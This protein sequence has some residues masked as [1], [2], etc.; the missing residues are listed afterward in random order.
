MPNIETKEKNGQVITFM[1]DGGYFYKKGIEAYQNQSVEKAIQFFERA[2]RIE[3]EEPVFACQL[4]I[5]LSEEGKYEESNAWLHKIKDE[6]DDSMSECYFFL[7]NNQAHLGEFDRASKNLET[8]LEIDEEGEFSEDAESL[9]AMISS[10]NDEDHIEGELSETEIKEQINNK[11]NY[12]TMKLLNSGKYEEAEEFARQII[13]SDPEHWNI[14]VYLADA[15]MN[16]GQVEEAYSILKNLLEKESPNFLASC[17]MTVLLYQVN[18]PQASKWIEKLENVYP[19]DDWDSYF[20]AR[21][22]HLVK[23][24]RLSYIW[25]KKRLVSKSTPEPAHMKHQWAIVSCQCGF[26]NT[27]KAIWSQ[28]KKDD[29]EN[30]YFL[31]ELLMQL[32]EGKNPA[33]DPEQFLYQ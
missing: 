20:L 23:Q 15:L 19:I 14:Y 10:Q 24:Y 27:A 28:M 2:I 5:V 17:Q 3:P 26:F 11:A 31:E 33:E 22:L 6:I 21:T 12:A 30:Q 1:Q 32:D 4:A 18:H 16:Q 29:P 9:L 13:A 7:A 25:Y 8:Y